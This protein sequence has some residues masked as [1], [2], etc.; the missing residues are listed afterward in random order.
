MV[1]TSLRSLG[2]SNMARAVG[3]E[4]AAVSGR[5]LFAMGR[6]KIPAP[7]PYKHADAAIIVLLTVCGCLCWLGAYWL[8]FR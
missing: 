2:S 1:G 7:P 5:L 3:L 8:F 4:N 6:D